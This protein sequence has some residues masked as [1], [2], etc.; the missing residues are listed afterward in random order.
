[1]KRTKSKRNWKKA[2]EQSG[3][4]EKTSKNQRQKLL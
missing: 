4:P 1:M 2:K 3:I